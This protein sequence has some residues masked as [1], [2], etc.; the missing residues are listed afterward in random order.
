MSVVVEHLPRIGV[1]RLSRWIFNCYVLDGDDGPVVVDAGLPEVAADLARRLGDRTPTAVV[2]THGHCDH[3]AG[4]P[5]LARRWG[6]RAHLPARSLPYLDGET[7]RQGRTT[8]A[9]RLL[10]T[11]FD[12][13][14]DLTGL[15]GFLASPK[16]AGYALTGS[17]TWDGPAPVGGLAD[18]DALP[19]AAQW[20]VLA[21]P[22]HTD[23][24]VALWHADT[25]TLLS[26]D[27]VLTARG[28]ARFTPEHVD[29]ADATA[30]MGRLLDLPV[31]H[32]LPGHGRP[33]HG[34]GA[35]DRLR[36]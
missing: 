28:R 21:V 20:R 29:L 22:G 7:P 6:V 9:W 8:Q 31:E 3:V 2:A 14:F 36:R 34:A 23:D 10:P 11:L 13:P 1:T 15:R 35:W 25:A 32:L 24:S 18:G 19:G 16:V 17:M 27:A 30:S 26:G 12:Q 33:I 4:V 5:G